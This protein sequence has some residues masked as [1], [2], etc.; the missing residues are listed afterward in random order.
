VVLALF[1]LAAQVSFGANPVRCK[2]DISVAAHSLAQAGIDIAVRLNF[3]N[4]HTH[5]HTP[6]HKKAHLIM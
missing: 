2:N 4:T 1:A 6:C 5:T 3:F